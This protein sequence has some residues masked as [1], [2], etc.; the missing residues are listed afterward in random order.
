MKKCFAILLVT[1][2]AVFWASSADAI[3]VTQARSSNVGYTSA[4]FI[5]T[6]DSSSADTL[7]DKVVLFVGTS[8]SSMTRLDSL[9]TLT[10]PDTISEAVGTFEDGT[11]YYWYITTEDTAGTYYH[12]FDY[13]T[14]PYQFTTTAFEQGA[15]ITATYDSAQII[16][17]STGYYVAPLDSLVLEYWATGDTTA[18]TITSVTHPDSFQVTSLEEGT[19]YNGIIIAYLADSSIVDTLSITFTTTDLQSSASILRYSVDSLIIIIDSVDVCPD[20]YIVQYGFSELTITQDS[21]TA[22][23]NT[24]PNCP[25]T[26]IFTGIPEGATLFYRVLYYASGADTGSIASYTRTHNVFWEYINLAGFWPGNI[27]YKNLWTITG[28]SSDYSTGPIPIEWPFI[29]IHAG[30]DGWDDISPGDST[31]AYIWSWDNGDSAIIDTL[32][33]LDPDTGNI[34][35]LS[36]RTWPGEF[37][38]TSS[39]IY[40]VYDWGTHFSISLSTIDTT[41][42]EDSTVGTRTFGIIIEAIK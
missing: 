20:S 17:D 42:Y 11:T 30:I 40:P 5:I 36:F 27:I 19:T 10:Y 28:A 3:T 4:D 1:I 6:I 8:I 34:T 9:T 21:A 12:P 33:A 13:F 25:D 31:A 38:D 18:D 23:T 2:L 16:H 37:T 39:Q 14:H 35:P 41:I 22:D 26:V 7:V 15:T 29:R 24:S 32:I